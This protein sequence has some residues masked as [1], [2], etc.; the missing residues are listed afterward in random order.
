M[1]LYRSTYG[2]YSAEKPTRFPKCCP[3]LLVNI[4]LYL[5]TICLR[6]QDL[7]LLNILWSIWQFM[8]KHVNSFHLLCRP[9]AFKVKLYNFVRNIIKHR[10]TNYNA[11][12]LNGHNRNSIFI[13]LNRPSKCL[14]F[15]IEYLYWRLKSDFFILCSKT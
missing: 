15:N 14:N 12:A 3:V 2:E 11:N 4:G 8:W 5:C 1:R 7:H 9:L 13:K 10:C 6:D